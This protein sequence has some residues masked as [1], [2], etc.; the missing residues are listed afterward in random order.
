LQN[1]AKV[2]HVNTYHIQAIKLCIWHCWVDITFF[3]DPFKS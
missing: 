1:V 3:M 2:D